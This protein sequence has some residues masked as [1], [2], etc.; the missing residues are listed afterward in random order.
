MKYKF[1]DN[2]EIKATD[3]HPFYVNGK[4]KAPLEVG[5]IV[6]NDDLKVIKVLMLIK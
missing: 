2:T 3:D 4:L 1:D 6:E 5:D